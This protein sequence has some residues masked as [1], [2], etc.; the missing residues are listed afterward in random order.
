MDSSP[1]QRTSEIRK[2]AF[3]VGRIKA[4]MKEDSD[5][6]QIAGDAAV[7]MGVAAELFLET[8]IKSSYDITAHDH[9][10]TIAYKDLDAVPDTIPLKK[11]LKL[12]NDVVSAT[13]DG[14]STA[15]EVDGGDA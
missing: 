8:L 11:A 4:I 2:P 1:S 9:R 10:K 5:V 13:A 12:R 14:G 6:A 7:V 15:M 3:P